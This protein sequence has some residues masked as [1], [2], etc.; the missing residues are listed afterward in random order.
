MSDIK[1]NFEKR[2][3]EELRPHPEN[4]RVFTEKGM[5]DLGKSIEKIGMA[6][7]IN[8]TQDGVVLSG[9]ARLMALKKKGIKEVDVY[10]ANR[11]LT[12]QEQKEV[13]IRMNA[14][15]AGDWNQDMLANNFETS[16]L[17]EWGL[18]LPWQEEPLDPDS[19]DEESEFDITKQK[20]KITF[21]YTDS[22][23]VIDAFLREMHEKYPE[24]LYTVEID[25]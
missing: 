13:L 20:V 11:D 12:P 4:P 22:H 19:Q 21:A 3:I 1:W 23:K 14:N 8:I 15:I 16:D 6:Q 9:H 10:V 25:D 2:K 18:D 24:L 17:L 5:R 7:P